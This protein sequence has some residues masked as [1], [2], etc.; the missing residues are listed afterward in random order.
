MLPLILGGV[1]L[2]GSLFGKGAQKSAE[3]RAQESQLIEQRNRTLSDNYATN[4]R[5]IL[6]A[7]GLQSRNDLDRAQFNIS[8]PSARMKQT[9]LGDLLMNRAGTRSQVSHPRAN[10]VNFRT[11]M[12]SLGPMSQLGGADLTL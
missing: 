6:E 1:S 8:A 4:Q 9:M 5:A 3:G 11:T 10:V 7:L 12:D 2:L